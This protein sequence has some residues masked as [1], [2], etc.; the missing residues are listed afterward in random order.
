MV[1]REAYQNP[2]Y[3][4]YIDPG[5]CLIQI[6]NRYPIKRL[7]NVPYIERELQQGVPLGAITRHLLVHSKSTRYKTMATLFKR[8][9]T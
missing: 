4:G 5:V 9:C 2:R 7:K 6:R 1:G 3:W 8:K